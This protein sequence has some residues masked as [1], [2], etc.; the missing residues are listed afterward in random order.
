METQNQKRIKPAVSDFQWTF[1]VFVPHCLIHFDV[2]SISRSKSPDPSTH[3][4]LFF[5]L[6]THALLVATR[7]A[8]GGVLAAGDVIL[9]SWHAFLR[10]F[11][12]PSSLTCLKGTYLN[13]FSARKQSLAHA[14]RVE[15]IPGVHFKSAVEGCINTESPV[16]TEMCAFGTRPTLCGHSCM[17]IWRESKKGAWKIWSL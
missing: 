3:A 13:G 11:L 2:G 9:Q 4:C 10:E 15:K 6:L 14:N 5:F 12:Q 16:M 8:C 7:L 17:K 1:L